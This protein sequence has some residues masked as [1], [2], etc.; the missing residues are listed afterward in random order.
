MKT[1][2]ITLDFINDICHPKGQIS[3]AA[4]RVHKNRVI[5]NTNKL[6]TWGR[7]RRHIICHI[8]VAFSTDYRESSSNSPLFSYIKD[9]GALRQK[10]WGT[11]FVD[12]LNITDSDISIYK[13]RV[14]GFYGTE[15]PVLIASNN[16]E[17]II[18]CG[19]ST[20]NTV[21]LTAREAHDRDFSVFIASDACESDTENNKQNSLNFL[22]KIASVKT[23]DEI[24][25]SEGASKP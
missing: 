15:L 11:A 8:R 24:I 21:E 6:L 9:I 10:S 1:A 7:A 19:V 20:Q 17:R 3:A 13:R 23:V 4:P 22:T 25:A 2:I 12:E 16:I 18:L 14:S 5:E